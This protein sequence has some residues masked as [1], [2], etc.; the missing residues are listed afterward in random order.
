MEEYNLLYHIVRIILVPFI[1]L[2][3]RPKVKGIE[4]LPKNGGTILYANHTS[5][6]DP[7]LL[8]CILPRK[9]NFMAKQE[10]FKYP[11]FGKILRGLGA[12]PVKRGSADIS[13][14][15]TAL[16]LLREGKV[17]GIF[18]EGTRNRSGSMQ[19]FTHG[20]AAIALKSKAV[21]VPVVIIGEYRLLH[22]IKV[23]VGK[24]SDLKKYH[25]MKSTSQ[26]LNQISE[27]MLEAIKKI[28]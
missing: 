27:E 8:G 19:G 11:L 2:L 14:I 21:C 17:F 25:G 16:R 15:K 24:P 5:L 3:Y 22:S 28:L 23:I 26:L 9:I 10:L 7:I 1:Y 18:P 13:A 6:L 4:N 12:F 20:T